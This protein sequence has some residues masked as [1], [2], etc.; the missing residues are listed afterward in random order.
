MTDGERASGERAP[1]EKWRTLPERVDLDQLVETVD[2]EPRVEHVRAV[3]YG[4]E[5]IRIDHA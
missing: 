4:A 1:T 5:F 3:N 2:L